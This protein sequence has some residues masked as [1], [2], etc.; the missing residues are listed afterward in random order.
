MSFF[1]P[2]LKID[3]I[4]KKTPIMFTPITVRTLIVK[5]KLKY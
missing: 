4:I 5:W 1:I 2:M 3:T